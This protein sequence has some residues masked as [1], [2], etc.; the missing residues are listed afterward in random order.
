MRCTSTHTLFIG[1]PE[2]KT[3][4]EKTKRRWADNIKISLNRRR[5]SNEYPDFIKG[6]GNLLP[7][8]ATISFSRRT[9]FHELVQLVDLVHFTVRILHMRTRN[10]Q[11]VCDF[12]HR[13]C[14]NTGSL[15][16]VILYFPHHQTPTKVKR[17]YGCTPIW[18]RLHA[19]SKSVLCSSAYLVSP[20]VRRSQL[21]LNF[22]QSSYTY[23]FHS[24]EHVLPYTPEVF[25]HMRYFLETKLP[26]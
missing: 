12:C 9:L 26:R 3:P 23:G 6:G 11:H 15:D 8:L 19:F 21:S 18:S 24:D 13:K 14:Q 4:L 22:Q 7:R 1:K 10:K 16:V 2:R 25:V 20:N 17:M 5:H